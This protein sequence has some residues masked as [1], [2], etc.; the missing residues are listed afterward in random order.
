MHY[1][2][3]S[4]A[5][6]RECI[7]TDERNRTMWLCRPQLLPLL[8]SERSSVIVKDDDFP[9]VRRSYLDELRWV[10][11]RKLRCA[12]GGSAYSV[13]SQS[14]GFNVNDIRPRPYSELDNFVR[15][16]GEQ[17]AGEYRRTVTKLFLAERFCFG[18]PVIV[19]LVDGV[20]RM[21]LCYLAASQLRGWADTS[22][23]T[24]S[25]VCMRGVVMQRSWYAC[26]DALANDGGTWWR[27]ASRA[28]TVYVC[29]AYG[30]MKGYK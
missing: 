25:A 28:I 13:N 27:V 23:G 8:L 11:L 26:A 20:L 24:K 18:F 2:Y 7:F 14:S 10:L 30:L 29:H 4:E 15:S 16:L 3:T 21:L 6:D 5:F 17:Y 1:T 12:P 22:L 19:G 9:P